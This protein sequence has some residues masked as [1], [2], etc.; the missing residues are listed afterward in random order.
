MADEHW[1]SA[2]ELAQEGKTREA[3]V[4]FEKIV[5]ADVHNVSAWFWYAKTSA[6]G[7]E[8]TR[9][10]QNCLRFNPD[11][12]ETRQVLGLAPLPQT[13]SPALSPQHTTS[14]SLS[15]TA[16]GTAAPESGS[17]E[18]TKPLKSYVPTL[19]SPDAAPAPKQNTIS[20]WVLLGAAILLIAL[21]VIAA[22][23][24]S[25]GV[26]PAPLHPADYRHAEAIGYSLYV[27]KAYAVEGLGHTPSISGQPLTIDLFRKTQDK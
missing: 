4:L 6:S 13:G 9:I 2:L 27:P 16:A 19:A 8:R 14:N 25:K 12:T 17:G 23:L 24:L 11:S 5:N 10:L 7:S 15:F 22:W 1:Q 21:I 26:L 20:R 18:N 3:H